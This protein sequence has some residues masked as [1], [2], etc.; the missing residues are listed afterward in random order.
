MAFPQIPLGELTALPQTS[1]LDLRGLLPTGGKGRE[2]E[3]EEE[4][5]SG[6]RGVPPFVAMG[7]R[8]VSLALTV[9]ATFCP[10]FVWKSN[11]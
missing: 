3:G 1:Y 5:G 9:N 2:G 10:S 11:Q 8:M 4:E 6:G 7:P